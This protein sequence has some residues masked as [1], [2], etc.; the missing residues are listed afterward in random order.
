MTGKALQ[1][2]MSDPTDDARHRATRARWQCR[3]SGRWHDP[4]AAHAG[5][6]PDFRPSD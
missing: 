4:D 5:P 6:A 3:S 2:A 1:A